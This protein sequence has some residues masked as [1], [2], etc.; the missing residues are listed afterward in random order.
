MEVSS[1][2][3]FE[4]WRFRVI[5]VSSYRG[6]SYRGSSYGGFELWRFRVIEVS[7][8]RGSSYRESTVVFL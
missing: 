6:S 1:Y 7:S 2:G 8:Y 4:L 5:E 3:G